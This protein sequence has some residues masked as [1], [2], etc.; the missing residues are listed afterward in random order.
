M[1]PDQVAEL[2][3]RMERDRHH[4]RFIISPE[5]GE[6]L[7]LKAYTREVVAHMEKDL[8]T[9][10]EWVAGQHHDTEHPTRAPHDP[11]QR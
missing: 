11:R 9:T 8:G 1:S 4:F 7:D 10:L 5:H 3:T 6:E 2:A